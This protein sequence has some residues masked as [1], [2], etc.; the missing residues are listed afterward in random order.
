MHLKRF[1]ADIVGDGIQTRAKRT[2]NTPGAL[3]LEPYES[4]FVSNQFMARIFCATIVRPTTVQV[5]RREGWPEWRR[6]RRRVL[7]PAVV[8]FHPRLPASRDFRKQRSAASKSG[9]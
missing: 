6:R 2:I 1:H 7:T 4:S 9:A 5:K 8:K 3:T